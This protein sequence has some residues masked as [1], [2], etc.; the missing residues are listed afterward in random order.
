MLTYIQREYGSRIL[1]MR[2]QLIRPCPRELQQIRWRTTTSTQVPHCSRA[3]VRRV[4]AANFILSSTSNFHNTP[5]NR[6]L[7]TT[8]SHLRPRVNF[9]AHS[10]QC[11]SH[12]RKS[13]GTA[14]ALSGGDCIDSG[15]SSS[16]SRWFVTMTA[17]VLATMMTTMMMCA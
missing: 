12:R 8:G 10:E 9:F 17:S 7:S 15:H 11:H 2:L 1:V 16:C 4:V 5:T 6:W 14:S 3:P 13:A